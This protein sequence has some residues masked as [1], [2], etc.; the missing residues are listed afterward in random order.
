[1]KRNEEIVSLSSEIMIDITEGRL[2][3]HVILLKASR[4]SSI[5]DMSK[6]VDLFEG[7]AKFAETNQFYVE[8]FQA[9]IDAAKDPNVSI[10]SANP[11]E[12][13]NGGFGGGVKGNTAERSYI[14][15][16]AS[17][18]VEFTAD[19]RTKT[20]TFAS[21][22]NQNWQFGHI[23]ESVFEKK[24]KRV[25]PILERVFPDTAQR[26]NSI[27]QNLRS[28]NSEDWKN[29]VGSCRALLM[30]IADLLNP[31]KS[32]ADK[33]RYINRLQDYIS[34]KV[35]SKTKRSLIK[36]HF[37]ELKKRIEHTMD[38]TQAGS[39]QGRPAREDAED[40]VLYT[41]LAVAELMQV[42]SQTIKSVDEE[43]INAVEKKL[44]LPPKKKK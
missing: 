21:R 13:V 3:L 33:G 6:N 31:P 27:E 8:T 35:A 23:A 10:S 17:K 29:A 38:L 2:P 40:V 9:S 5:L 36:N 28:D 26:L 11:N 16:T 4:L 39:H 12:W 24:R 22:I 15:N 19:Y 18:V 41:Y 32:T 43:T 20:Y 14:R 44:D 34:P 30:D 7:W 42:Y 37:E 25:E 1:M